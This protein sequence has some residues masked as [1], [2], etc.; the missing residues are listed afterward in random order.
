MILIPEEMEKKLASLARKYSHNFH[1]R[2]DG[3][4]ELVKMFGDQVD[5]RIRIVGDDEI[6]AEWIFWTESNGTEKSDETW[7]ATDT[8]GYSFYEDVEKFLKD[9]LKL[10]KIEVIKRDGAVIGIV[11]I[12]RHHQPP[13]RTPPQEA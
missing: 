1:K 11:T 10:F 5:N 7:S 6:M 13:R 2:N 4:V 8:E 12:Q 9:G 3:S